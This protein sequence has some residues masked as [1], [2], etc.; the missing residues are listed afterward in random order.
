MEEQLISRHWFC[1]LS[2]CRIPLWVL[3]ILGW[4]L[5]GFPHNVS[6]HLWRVRVWLLSQF[7][8]KILFIYSW[9]TRPELKADAQPLSHPGFPSLPIWMPF[10]PFC[11]L[12]SEARTSST[13]LSNSGESGHSCLSPFLPWSHEQSLGWPTQTYFCERKQSSSRLLHHSGFL[14][15]PAKSIC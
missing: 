7:L 11:C 2:C 5:L 12:I 3:A 14:F 8:K 6:C 13:L 10:I 9:E 1:I 15:Y 4:S